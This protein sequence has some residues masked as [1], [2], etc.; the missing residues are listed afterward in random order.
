MTSPSVCGLLRALDD[1][2][3]AIDDK[4][5]RESSWRCADGASSRAARRG[6][7]RAM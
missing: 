6:W 4:G 3:A 1:L 2:A 7:I 5:M